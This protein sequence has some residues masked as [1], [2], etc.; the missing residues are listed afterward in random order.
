MD[1]A[2]ETRL[3]AIRK[4]SANERRRHLGRVD[5]ASRRAKARKVLATVKQ[6][7]RIVSEEGLAMNDVIEALIERHRIVAG[8][9][10]STLPRK[11]GAGRF[12]N[13]NNPEQVWSGR[14]RRPSWVSAV[15]EHE[16]IEIEEFRDDVRFREEIWDETRSR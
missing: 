9:R 16:C 8:A 13:P 10:T 7:E 6:V 15:L 3:E 2:I 14:G 11:R 5:A 1:N 4:M 12:R